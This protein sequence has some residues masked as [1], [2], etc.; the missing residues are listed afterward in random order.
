MAS[1]TSAS[2]GI[3]ITIA[4][5]ATFAVGFLI[6]SVYFY[7][8]KS[9]AEGEVLNLTNTYEEIIRTGERQSSNV[10][11]AL[12]ASRAQGQSL[13][14]HL[15]T[16]NSEL[17]RL[18]TGNAN[19]TIEQMRD[20]ADELTGGSGSL[21]S[22][23]TRLEGR[24]ESLER[25]LAQAEGRLATELANIESEKQRV[26]QLEAS[27]LQTAAE[28]NDRV[29][30]YRREVED[31]RAQVEGFEARTR[32]GVESD[33]AEYRDNLRDRDGRV[34][35]LNQQIL[36]LRDQVRRLRGE[37]TENRISPV[38]EYALVDGEVAAVQQGEDLVIITL[39]RNDKL[40]I[41]M[42]FSVYNNP[43]SIRPTESGEYLPGKAVLEVVGMESTSARCRVVKSSRGN[44]VVV[45]D[46][47]ANPVYDPDKT[48]NFVVFGNFDTD[49]DGIA[50][51]FERQALVAVIERWGGEVLDDIS[52]DLDFLVLG[53]RPDEPLQPAPNAPR[54]VYDEYLR[55]KNRVDR[56]EELFEVASA[57]SI[58]V[59]NQNRLRTLIGELPR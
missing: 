13:V 54:V 27:A 37:T 49:G 33:R 59:L 12:S 21:G 36:V 50:T 58:P 53:E 32:R 47:I 8:K 48:Y 6:A 10:E 57:S 24:V 51:P 2:T 11:A 23:I 15:L 1:R 29:G 18:A 43:S 25:E 7:S 30:D 35:E 17:K 34:A 9:Q 52:G 42:T 26:N 38:D 41:G 20:R 56:Y 16:T 4:L 22:T 19:L 5:L 31:L 44:P 40:V 46:V 3:Y 28:A 45:G 14:D 39:G 55:L